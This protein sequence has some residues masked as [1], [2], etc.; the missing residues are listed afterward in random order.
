[1]ADVRSAII[2][3]SPLD[4]LANQF[5]YVHAMPVEPSISKPPIERLEC[6][7][8]RQ[9]GVTM[10]VL[11]LDKIHPLL[12]GNKWFKLKYNLL[13]FQHRRELPVLSFGGAY[14]NHLYALSAAG[15]LL[16]LRTIGM[17]RGEMPEPL[18]PIL[19]FAAEQGMRLVPLSRSDYRR[20]QDPDFIEELRARFGEIHLL[21][22]GGSNALALR[23]CEEIAPFLHW[24]DEGAGRLVA[25]CCGTGTT[26]AGLIR[27]LS[28][29]DADS[30]VDVLG[31]SVLKGEGYLHKEVLEQLQASDY[32]G[33]ID[34]SVDDGHHCGGY[35]RSNEALQAF[36]SEFAGIS[37]LAV[38][39]VYTGK[40][41][42]ALFDLI[43]KGAICPGTEI[44]A[45]HSGGFYS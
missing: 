20:R 15:K 34:W 11:R 14:S 17:V 32:E 6:Q 5:Q 3:E 24:R 30:A 40:L 37:D 35:A 2:I 45:I 44:V 19:S 31:I 8:L 1:M 29:I 26:M 38:E 21:P 23:G 9:A 27:G 33:S 42:Y 7:F 39:P 22:E 4:L 41:F 28:K 16:G 12:S 10:R 13:E 43:E 25:L 36:L 18:N